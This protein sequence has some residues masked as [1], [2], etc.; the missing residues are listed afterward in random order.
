[1]SPSWAAQL[2]V[3]CI[4]FRHDDLLAGCGI[5]VA[6]VIQL[7]SKMLTGCVCGGIF[8]GLFTN[9]KSLRG[10]AGHTSVL[11]SRQAVGFISILRLPSSVNRYEEDDGHENDDDNDNNLLVFAVQWHLLYVIFCSMALTHLWG[12]EERGWM[13][14]S[15]GAVDSEPENRA[16][17]QMTIIIIMGRR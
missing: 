8:I 5:P 11:A 13:E 2:L 1:M 6:T 12:R 9:W 17:Q 4:S 15:G 3:T 10:T 7:S 16:T 14:G